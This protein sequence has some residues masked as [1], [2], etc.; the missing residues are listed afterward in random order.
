MTIIEEL[1]DLSKI[2]VNDHIKSLLTYKMKRKPK[3]K[4]TKTK[5]DIT[6]HVVNEKE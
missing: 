5:K 2:G 1:K 3:E 4:E 6:L